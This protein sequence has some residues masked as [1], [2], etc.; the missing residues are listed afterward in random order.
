MLVQSTLV[1]HPKIFS[2][3]NN[4]QQT[5]VAAVAALT[6]ARSPPQKAFAFTVVP[7]KT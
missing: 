1:P 5:V 4:S 6:V 2:K 7:P 3:N